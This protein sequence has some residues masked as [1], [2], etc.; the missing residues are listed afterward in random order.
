MNE[1]LDKNKLNK[2]MGGK[3]L[4]HTVTQTVKDNTL[5]TQLTLIKY[6]NTQ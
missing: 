3:Y 5:T 1:I 2:Q 4:V 6:G